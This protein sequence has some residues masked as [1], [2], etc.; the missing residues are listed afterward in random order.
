M[1]ALKQRHKTGKGQYIDASMFETCA[2][3]ITPAFLELQANK[4]LPSRSGNRIAYA[5][6]HGVFPCKGD[7]KWCA[8]TV[9][10][11]EEWHAFCHI[12]NNPWTKDPRF[13]TLQSRKENEDELE[14]LVADWT[15]NYSPQE[16]MTILQ[17]EGVPAG[18]VQDVQEIMEEDPQ[19]KE[20]GFLVLLKHPVL[21]V[22]NHPNPPYKLS[23]TRVQIK[24][25]PCL[26]EHTEYVCTKILGMSDQ[27]FLDL[28]QARVFK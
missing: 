12:I 11:N 24:T 22:F 18:A 16:V 6:P 14:K 7:D 9:F 27:E 8:I 4:H 15:I 20:R 26:G 21:G 13:A 2:Q 10:T 19:M 3:S 28:F 23:K 1:A 5:S 25:S 17:A